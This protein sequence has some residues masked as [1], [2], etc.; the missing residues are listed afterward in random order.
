[1]IESISTLVLDVTQPMQNL[2]INELTE[3]L[4][5]ILILFEK[6]NGA[7]APFK[8]QSE[9]Y[10]NPQISK[11]DVFVG[12]KP[13]HL[14]SSGVP[15]YHQ[16]MASLKFF[17]AGSK[18]EPTV[19]QVAKDLHLVDMTLRQYLTDKYMLWLDFRGTDNNQLQG[20]GRSIPNKTSRISLAITK[21]VQEPGRLIA[22]VSYHG[23]PA[24]YWKQAGTVY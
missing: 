18:R 13:N 23:H 8:R 15:P 5:G 24:R 12:G 7:A 14:F 10:I 3:S 20:S 1:M 9:T 21:D 11:V 4:V 19:T 17:A 22:H 2:Y 16:S 6:A